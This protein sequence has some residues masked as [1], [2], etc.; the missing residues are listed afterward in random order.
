MTVEAAPLAPQPAAPQ[1]HEFSHVA[2]A[3]CLCAWLLSLMA[4]WALAD[5]FGMQ[6]AVRQPWLILT[7]M[8]LL[9]LA[10]FVIILPHDLRSRFINIVNWMGSVALLMALFAGGKV[11]M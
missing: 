1:L 2:L 6:E 11:Q 7:A 4:K 8:N 10:G 9:V 3:I 5:I